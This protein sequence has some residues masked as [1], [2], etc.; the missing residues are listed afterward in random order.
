MGLRDPR[1]PCTSIPDAPAQPRHAKT[2]T[3][4]IRG[5][6]LWPNVAL[7]ICVWRCTGFWRLEKIGKGAADQ[8]AIGVGERTDEFSVDVVWYGK[9]KF[10]NHI[11]LVP[12]PSKTWFRGMSVGGSF[13]R[14]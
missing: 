8:V 13:R 5:K 2:P 1:P 3:A 12:S 10:R 9:S 4:L 6:F 7:D 14:V 11:L